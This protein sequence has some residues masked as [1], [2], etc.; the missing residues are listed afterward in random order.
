MMGGLSPRD[1]V[2]ATQKRADG[3]VKGYYVAGTPDLRTQFFTVPKNKG[4]SIISEEANKRALLP[5]PNK[6]TIKPTDNWGRGNST[7]GSS[8]VLP[9]DKRLTETDRIELRN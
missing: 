5:G 4:L 7:N 8:S 9:K 2:M 3:G 1:A 6:Y